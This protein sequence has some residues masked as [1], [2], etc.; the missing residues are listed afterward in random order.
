MGRWAAHHRDRKI[1]HG[2]RA[3][4][5]AA[6]FLG[7]PF[8]DSPRWSTKTRC[9]W[10][11]SS[12]LRFRSPD[13]VSIRKTNISRR[14]GDRFMQ[15]ASPRAA[16][17]RLISTTPS[18]SKIPPW[19]RVPR[20]GAPPRLDS[21]TR[22][23]LVGSVIGLTNHGILDF[24]QAT[25]PISVP[26]R[27]TFSREGRIS[28]TTMSPSSRRIS[29][30]HTGTFNSGPN[31]T[32]PGS[33]FRVSAMEKH[34][35]TFSRPSTNLRHSCS[36]PFAGISNTSMT[37]QMARAARCSSRPTFHDWKPASSIALP[38]TFRRRSSITRSLKLAVM[39]V[40]TL[41]CK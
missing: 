3:L 36:A 23:L 25:A 12:R 4:G 32:R 9:L 2:F 1:G 11:T 31:F 28:G 13:I 29:L 16:R 17:L 6:P 21:T 30:T 14:S 5:D 40:T 33:R 39:L 41:R 10:K 22:Q 20:A 7:Q 8:C 19:L 35:A 34:S 24:P 15:R 18:G 27:R 37:F 26:R 38:N